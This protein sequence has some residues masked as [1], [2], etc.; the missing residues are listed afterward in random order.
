MQTSNR[1]FIHF[2]LLLAFLYYF[3]YIQL[4]TKH[5][6]KVSRDKKINKYKV[7]G[8]DILM[9]AADFILMLYLNKWWSDLFVWFLK[10][11]QI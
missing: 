3:I 6:V 5:K 9:T 11:P 4:F 10:D 7:W 2:S 8:L 1:I